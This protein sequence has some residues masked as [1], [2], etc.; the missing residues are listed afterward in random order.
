[1]YA[2]YNRRER[3]IS[4]EAQHCEQSY[5][6]RNTKTGTLSL[7]SKLNAARCYLTHIHITYEIY[8]VYRI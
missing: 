2:Q 7:G 6:L 8:S 1:M 3:T 4:E 5:D